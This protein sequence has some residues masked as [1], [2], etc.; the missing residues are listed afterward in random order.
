M[1]CDQASTWLLTSDSPAEPP[2]PVARHLAGC[3]ACRR[4]QRRLA[5]VESDI[6][7]LVLPNEC[8]VARDRFLK[9]ISQ[10]PEH[11]TGIAVSS[12]MPQSVPAPSIITPSTSVVTTTRAAR[13][14]AQTGFRRSVLLWVTAAAALVL[15]FFGGWLISTLT[16]DSGPKGEKVVEQSRDSTNG[17]KGPTEVPQPPHV[18]RPPQIVTARPA[19]DL[20]DP[21]IDNHIRLAAAEA[22]VQ[23]FELV[24]E[25]S[26]VLWEEISRQAGSKPTADLLVLS[27]L[28]SQV[29][30]DALPIR[31]Q[32]LGPVNQAARERVA[33]VLTDRQLSSKQLAANAIPTVGEVLLLAG[34]RSGQAAKLI[35]SGELPPDSELREPGK[36]PAN[37]LVSTVVARSLKLA[38]ADDPL[39]RASESS[40]LADDLS[41]SIV[42]TSLIGDADTSE[43]LGAYLGDV[44]DR[45]VMVNLA[46]F[47]PEGADD[48]RLREF[49]QIK[50][51]G[52]QAVEVLRRNLER[53][54]EPARKGLL[55]AIEAKQHGR[56]KGPPPGKGRRGDRGDDDD[57]TPPGLKGRDDPN[58]ARDLPE[59]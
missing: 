16:T 53:A 4:V 55:R 32:A 34:D 48:A 29:V 36:I 41:R 31:S 7:T 18:E 33:N 11:D 47:E 19:V 37:D 58:P 24:A 40:D 9:R 20:L 52:E 42:F 2:A 54:P 12:K 23:R 8:L 51:R 25:L 5:D 13:R 6:A 17:Q 21:L 15:A 3:A 38:E 44:V 27:Q 50:R 59:I 1:K 57:F 35:V 22:P 30:G 56:G 43:T 39:R 46:R 49:E 28:Y 26:D 14:P 10:L 45:G